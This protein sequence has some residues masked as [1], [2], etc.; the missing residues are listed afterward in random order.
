MI[1]P[2]G[3]VSQTASKSSIEPQYCASSSIFIVRP[4]STVE[5]LEQSTLQEYDLVTK[6]VLQFLKLE[7][8]TCRVDFE[9]FVK[10]FD[11]LG[12]I[13]LDFRARV[14]FAS[15]SSRNTGMDSNDIEI[16]LMLHDALPVNLDVPSIYE[17]FSSYDLDKQGGL[18]FQ[19]F[20]ECLSTPGVK[21][22]LRIRD[23]STLLFLFRKYVIK[24]VI[25]FPSF[26]SLWTAYFVEP[27]HE[28]HQRDITEHISTRRRLLELFVPILKRKRRMKIISE[29]VLEESNDYSSTFEKTRLQIIAR[30]KEVR[31]KVE[32]ERRLENKLIHKQQRQTIVEESV[33][34]REIGKFLFKR[35]KEAIHLSR[36]RNATHKIHSDQA[37]IEQEERDAIIHNLKVKD[38]ID[39]E[40][41]QSTARDR[42]DFAQ[43]GLDEVPKHLFDKMKLMD[44]KIMDFSQNNITSLPHDNFFFWLS[45]MRKLALSGNGIQSLPDELYSLSRLEILLLDGNQIKDLP[46][47]ISQLSTLVV[48]DLSNN[49]L[50]V[51]PPD[52]CDL[53]NL[54]VLIAHSNELLTLPT[55][56][57]RLANLECLDLSSNKLGMI[58]VSVCTIGGLFSL[59]LS[60]NRLSY[61]PQSIGALTKLEHLDI[62]YNNIWVSLRIKFRTSIPIS[63]L[64]HLH[65]QEIPDSM[66]QAQKLCS[67]MLDENKITSMPDCFRGMTKLRN[68]SCKG[69]AIQ[70]MSLEVGCM[71]VLHHM[72]CGS[73]S[74][75]VNVQNLT[76]CI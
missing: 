28:L 36:R 6:S 32:V 44:V 35:R 27:K 46:S 56:M 23:T 51:F 66:A 43:N 58:P 63:I 49:E 30:R 60:S 26:V 33:R 37:V 38:I 54:K 64:T 14:L 9:T 12:V 2:I 7:P 57:G 8:A 73:N 71:H 20:Q 40:S 67:L 13:I 29:A 1:A 39:T 5:P 50:Q 70:N 61:L 69:N 17:I 15:C 59:K 22:K 4:L 25:S 65:R 19:Q 18:T 74:V 62:S 11:F 53:P 68:F 16:S 55:D 76:K 72:N 45:S 42:M 3:D 47:S 75:K 34:G 21:S 10:G 52:F 31:L 48:L 41:I 24:K